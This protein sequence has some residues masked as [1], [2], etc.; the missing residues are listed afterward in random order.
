M[1]HKE[2]LLWLGFCLLAVFII[3][4]RTLAG[5]FVFDDRGIIDHQALLSNLNKFDQVLMLPYFTEAA[6]LYRP[7][8]L[9]SYTF[10]FVILGSSPWGFH[11]INLLLYA[12]SIFLIALILKRLFKDKMLAYL[13]AALFLVL[14]IHTEVV[15]NIVGRAEILALL[16][17]LLVFW[18][19]LKK[20]IVWW[21][22][23]IWLALALGSKETAVA[24][25]PI[26]FLIVYLKE[27][28]FF[29][30]F[31]LQKY[32]KTFLGLVSGGAF[33]FGLR[34]LVLGKV[35]FLKAV[36][37][38][39]ENPLQFVSAKERIAT[40]LG[41]LTMYVEKSFW[42]FN[43]C[44]DYSFNQLPIIKSFLS[45]GTLIGILIIIFFSSAIFIFLRRAPVLALASAILIFSYLPIANLIFS[46]GTIAGE[47]LMFYP[48]LGLCLFFVWLILAIYRLKPKKILIYCCLMFLLAVFIFY[49]FLSFKR[50]GDWQ[51]EKKL[52]TSAAK[53]AP[54][55]VLSQSN[56]GAAYYLDGDLVNAKIALLKAEQIYDG[57]PKG[58]NNLGLVYWKEGDRELAKK[59]FLHALDFEFPYYGAYENLALMA[60]EDKNWAE[61]K[62]WLL[63]LYSGNQGA[64]DSYIAPYQGF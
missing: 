26:A 63:E 54:N 56:L 43:L 24:A 58:I 55:S 23:G 46:T 45:P 35:Y 27:P 30:R 57:Y 59:Y 33:Y 49:G 36:T 29:S 6:G 10:N 13:T 21:R 40:A 17:S 8:V 52:F 22:A 14:P 15:A 1:L 11:L 12:A 7:T 31:I 19:L 9:A 5:E 41:V 16:F 60:I 44:S 61:A 32:G 3:Y 62:K 39:V 25:V 42:P 64:V 51:T 2:K 28:E 20:D 38:I 53:C 18:E 37:S 47:R 34:F 50:S 4:G 48:S